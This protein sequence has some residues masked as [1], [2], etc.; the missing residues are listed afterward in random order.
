M[1]KKELQAMLTIASKLGWMQEPAIQTIQRV[2]QMVKNMQSCDMD[3]VGEQGSFEQTILLLADQPASILYTCQWVR[4]YQSL[5]DWQLAKLADEMCM[6]MEDA[7]AMVKY[8]ELQDLSELDEYN[9]YSQLCNDLLIEE[10]AWYN[11]M[12]R[13]GYE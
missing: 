4:D 9:L 5:Q 10:M 2:R 13:L 8:Y 7:Y 3:C 6:S 12:R 1:N 11:K